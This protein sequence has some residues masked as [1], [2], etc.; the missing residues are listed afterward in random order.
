[1]MLTWSLLAACVVTFFWRAAG[2][3]AAGR[4]RAHSPAF[5][6]AACVTYAMVGALIL[7]LIIYPQGAAA[8]TELTHRL[9]AVAGVL[10]VYALSRNVA[11]SAWSGA[12]LLWLLLRAG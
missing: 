11:A 8:E 5:N 9:L 4:V 12:L 6:A 3:L 10:L 1:M 7:K 2:A